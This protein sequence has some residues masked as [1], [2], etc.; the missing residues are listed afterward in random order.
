MQ[1]TIINNYFYNST[2][3]Y[4]TMMNGVMGQGMNNQNIMYQTNNFNGINNSI[5]MMNFPQMQMPSFPQ[6]TGY[7]GLS[8]FPTAFGNSFNLLGNTGSFGSSLLSGLNGFSGLAGL[9]GFGTSSVSNYI[10]ALSNLSN[11]GGTTTNN[12]YLQYLQQLF[13]NVTGGNAG[14]E[15][16]AEINTSNND[17]ISNKELTSYLTDNLE[18]AEEVDE[19]VLAS[20]VA[21]L[22]DMINENCDDDDEEITV[23][24]LTEFIDLDADGVITDDEIEE[25]N[26]NLEELLASTNNEEIFNDINTGDDE[27]INK[28]ELIA[29]VKANCELKAD[30]SASLLDMKIEEFIAAVAGDEAE[31]SKD[32]LIAYIGGEDG[33]ISSDDLDLFVEELQTNA[34]FINSIT[35]WEGKNDG[36]IDWNRD[37]QANNETGT[38]DTHYNS[39]VTVHGDLDAFMQHYGYSHVDG[40]NSLFK[41]MENYDNKT[42]KGDTNQAEDFVTY[43]GITVHQI[44]DT[45]IG[46]TITDKDRSKATGAAD[47]NYA[48]Y[49]KERGCYILGKDANKDG[50][51]SDD[52]I[53]GM[54]ENAQ[55]R[56]A[57]PL[58]FDLNGDGVSTTGINKEYDLDGDGTIDQTAWAD[59]NDGVL[60]FDAD[61]DGLIGED[62]KELFGNNTDIDGDGKKDGFQ[63]GFEALK[64]LALK[65]LGKEAVAD[66]KLDA[67]EIKK[68]ETAANLKMMVNGENKSLTELGITEISLGY[69]EA[70]KNK[71]ANGNEHRQVG[72]GFVINGQTNQVNDVWYRYISGANAA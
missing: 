35:K 66:N 10:Q 67:A 15:F 69:T 23:E 30:A 5:P 27:T 18:M 60:A 46:F 31:I 6:M 3:N 13:G 72:N 65:F 16:I 38:G 25:F 43:G 42:D 19:T 2:P 33:I 14:S 34:D 40:I 63:N 21:K 52:E 56:T 62:G 24:E 32:Q 54:V 47:Y 20:T 28:D 44:S 1:P 4:M 68:L 57:S 64:A 37:G 29:Y 48:I 70:G 39:Y 45:Q 8:Q 22:R 53:T 50:L 51:L 61:G 36:Y 11:L 59:A 9:T 49:D 12:S 7:T 58:T 26:Y 71:D 41:I 17:T 55:V